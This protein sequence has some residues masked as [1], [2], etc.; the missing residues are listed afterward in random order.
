M[1]QQR[2]SEAWAQGHRAVTVTAG[3]VSCLSPCNK[4]GQELGHLWKHPSPSRQ[5][6][7]SPSLL[8]P[9][10]Q[11]L[12]CREKVLSARQQHGPA[13]RPPPPQVCPRCRRWGPWPP[14]GT[15]RMCKCKD[16]LL[17]PGHNV[18]DRVTPC[19]WKEGVPICPLQAK[20]PPLLLPA[21]WGPR[22]PPRLP[23]WHTHC[24]FVGRVWR[25]PPHVSAWR[26]TASHAASV[27]A[28]CRL[29]GKMGFAAK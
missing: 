6:L 20:P 26:L 14:K 24:C 15:A 23:V 29:R 12:G 11:L 27:C 25:N 1:A 17:L 7:P 3:H 4:D 19:S 8:S 16:F 18:R 28:A 10:P 9:T 13:W 2:P 21:A 22:A 5:M